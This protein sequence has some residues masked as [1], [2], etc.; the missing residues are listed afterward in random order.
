M[1]SL[2][3]PSTLSSLVIL[4]VVASCGAGASPTGGGSEEL[5]SGSGAPAN[6]S[7]LQL[8]IQ[9]PQSVLHSGVRKVTVRSPLTSPTEGP[10]GA[11][12]V[13]FYEQIHSDGVSRFALEPIGPVDASLPPADNWDLFAILQNLRQ[14]YYVHYRDFQVRDSRVF[15]SEWSF[16]ELGVDV[17]VA[18]RTCRRVDVAHLRSRRSYRLSVD[19]ET[20]LILDQIELDAQGQLILQ[21]TYESLDLTPDLTNIVWHEPTPKILFAL[22]A[23]LD[24]HFGFDIDLPTNLPPGYELLSLESLDTTAKGDDLGPWLRAT[25][26]NGVDPLFYA[27]SI[28]SAEFVAAGGDVIPAGRNSPGN[29]LM[30][31]SLGRASTTFGELP[32]GHVMA[33]GRV[34]VQELGDL[35]HSAIR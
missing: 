27:L 7:T 13:Q 16:R 22:D 12:A 21:V 23:D 15:R 11:S 20:G 30:I 31:F 9:D 24:V 10:P 4:F 1:K 33:A 32:Q 17:I 29:R 3:L 19:E 5:T 2:N 25:Y 14:S 28:P 35:I 26:T 8:G 6:T 34:S 18:G